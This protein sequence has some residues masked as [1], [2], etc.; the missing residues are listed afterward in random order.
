MTITCC[1]LSCRSCGTRMCPDMFQPSG[2]VS[3][4]WRYVFVCSPCSQT[5]PVSS[6][7]IIEWWTSWEILCH[8]RVHVV[9]WTICKTQLFC[10]FSPFS[11]YVMLIW[12]KIPGSPRISVLQVTESWWKR[13]YKMCSFTFFWLGTPLSLIHIWRCRRYSLCRSRWSPYH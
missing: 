2:K 6:F 7:A 5:F 9:A 3:V 11:N 13:G 1:V 8:E 4:F 12:E 10:R